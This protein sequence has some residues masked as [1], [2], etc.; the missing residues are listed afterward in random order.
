MILVR[1]AT[2]EIVV[3]DPG[4]PRTFRSDPVIN[5]ELRRL[6]PSAQRR[7]DEMTDRERS[8]WSRF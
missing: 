3:L 5:L 7:Y 4:D 8:D 6:S 2:M 1:V